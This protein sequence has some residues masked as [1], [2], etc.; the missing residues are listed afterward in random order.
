MYNFRVALRQCGAVPEISICPKKMF[1]VLTDGHIF[2]VV[3]GQLDYK[4]LLK[5]WRRWG[6]G[7]FVFL[8]KTISEFHSTG[9]SV[10]SGLTRCCSAYDRREGPDQ[11]IKKVF[12]YSDSDHNQ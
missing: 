8:F 4:G 9:S 11:I 7:L 3:R 1:L 6:R 5:G 10:H 12:Q 2:T